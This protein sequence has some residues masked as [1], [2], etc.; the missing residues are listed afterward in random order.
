MRN[1]SGDILRRVE[2]GESVQ[3]TN[4]GRLA[5]LIIPIGGDALDGLVARGEARAARSGVETLAQIRRVTSP[6]STEAIL[7]D[8]RG[9]W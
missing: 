5:A 9:R 3:V 1:Q 8:S 2:A 4:N 6:I 7:N